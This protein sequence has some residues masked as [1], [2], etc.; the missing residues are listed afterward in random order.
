M[1]KYNTIS[2]CVV[3]ASKEEEFSSTLKFKRKNK[4]MLRATFTDGSSTKIPI[5][6]ILNKKKL[7]SYP[8]VQKC[9]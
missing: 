8:L 1:L 9:S 7:T 4:I 6:P 3:V 2:C 5:F